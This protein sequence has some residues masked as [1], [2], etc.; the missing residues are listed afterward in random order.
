MKSQGVFINNVTEGVPD[1][2]G[3][4]FF[5][6][7]FSRASNFYPVF[8]G[9][10]FFSRSLGGVQDF[11]LGENV[12]LVSPARHIIVEHSLIFPANPSHTLDFFAPLE[13]FLLGFC[14]ACIQCMAWSL[15]CSQCQFQS[16]RTVCMLGWTY[17]NPG[18]DLDPPITGG[19]VRIFSCPLY[20]LC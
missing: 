3:Y 12:N 14:E 7:E 9:I 11:F 13:L 6:R 17:N 4:S 1:S 20:V 15:L 8:R 10:E 19:Y 2:L 5:P 16:T 18:N